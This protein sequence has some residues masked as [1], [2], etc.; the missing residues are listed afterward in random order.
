MKSQF[1][2]V[3]MLED[4]NKFTTE[5]CNFIKLNNLEKAYNYVVSLLLIIAYLESRFFALN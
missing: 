3:N 5:M 2:V 1:S 4:K